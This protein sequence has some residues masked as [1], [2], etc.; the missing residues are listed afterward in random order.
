MALSKERVAEIVKQ[1]GK[2]A[3]DSGSPA[4]QI[5]LLTEQIVSLTEHLKANKKDH[6]SRRGLLIAV[7]KRRSLLDYL[8][9]TD[10]DAYI[11]LITNLGIRK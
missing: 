5:A 9:R 4:V 2:N 11:K 8:N 10:R 7:G 6:H 3:S 1:Y